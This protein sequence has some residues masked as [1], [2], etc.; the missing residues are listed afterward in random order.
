[1][2]EASLDRIAVRSVGVWTP[3]GHSTRANVTLDRTNVRQDVAAMAPPKAVVFDNDGLLLDTEEAWTRAERTLFAR[4][5]REFTS[6]H[7]RILIGSSRSLAAEKLEAIL[8]LLGEGEALMDEL[9]ELVMEEALL[10]VEPRPGAL[11]LLARL[12]EAG[13][14]LALASNSE[15]AFVQR[16]L[17]S[18]GLFPDG[19]F[20]T[21][22]TAADVANPKPAPDIYLEAC[23]RLGA[24]PASCAAL[25]DSPIGVAAAASAGML[26]I[27]VPYFTGTELPGAA[28]NA[29]SLEDT[30]VVETLGLSA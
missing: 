2:C 24:A 18:A 10:G 20:E 9:H 25:E 15:P 7:K 26:V 23:G 1:M 27:G 19:P 3:L 11:R 4:R 21:I 22:V 14:P 5:G 13:V 30:I 12:Q 16:T 8:G 17:A 6:E 29:G 28:V